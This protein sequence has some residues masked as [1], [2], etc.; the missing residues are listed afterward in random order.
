ME[1]KKIDTFLVHAKILFL[2][3]ILQ[4]VFALWVF[5]LFVIFAKMNPGSEQLTND[6]LSGGEAAAQQ[7]I[8]V[9]PAN[10]IAPNPPEE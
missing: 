7:Q 1:E 8:P 5:L 10:I 6:V 4:I 2:S 9:F 3:W